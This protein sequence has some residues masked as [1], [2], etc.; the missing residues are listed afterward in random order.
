VI[1][2]DDDQ[3]RINKFKSVC[4]FADIVNTPE[5]TI[6]AIKKY[7]TVHKLFL[8]NDL[9]GKHYCDCSLPD[10]GM[11]VVRWIVAN[12]PKIDVIFVHTHNKEASMLMSHSLLKAGYKVCRLAFIS[13]KELDLFDSDVHNNQWIR[14]PKP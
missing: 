2:L 10:T 8:D 7:D 6:A 12:K 1:F 3:G 5:E 4:P 13:L 9:G 14:S 11:E